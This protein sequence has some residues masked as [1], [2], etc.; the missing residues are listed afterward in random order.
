MPSSTLDSIDEGPDIT[1]APAMKELI[2]KIDQELQS[3]EANKTTTE[4]QIGKLFKKCH[5]ALTKLE[6]ELK[7]VSNNPRVDSGDL[8]K[9]NIPILR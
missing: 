9:S 3:L 7:Q 4:E 6:N 8:Q 5:E 1:E 2:T